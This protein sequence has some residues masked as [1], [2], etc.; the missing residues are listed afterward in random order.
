MIKIWFSTLIL[1]VICQAQ[2]LRIATDPTTP[3][4]SFLDS[5]GAN[6]GLD[7]ELLA[8]VA[9]QAGV[10]YELVP[11]AWTDLFNQVQN[12]QVDLAISDI[13]INDAREEIYDFSVPYY[14]SVH[15]ILAQAGTDITSAQDLVSLNKIVGARDATISLA[16]VER[17]LGA[18]NPNIRKFATLDEGAQALGNGEIDAYVDDGGLVDYYANN[19]PGFTVIEDNNA[20][21]KEFYG[22]MFPKGS[23]LKAVF[24]PAITAVLENGEYDRIY[25]QWFGV[26]PDVALLLR[27]GEDEDPYDVFDEE[28]EM[29]WGNEEWDD[30]DDMLDI[31]I[32]VTL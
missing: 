32:S 9:Q 28:N 29:E 2:N 22:L 31:D 11:L 1:L 7:I 23:A 5:A 24:D 16:A 19:N 4:F 12:A 14:L 30:D 15:K 3:P 21:E 10:Q 17:I 20:F 18:D 26:A 8:A 13:T 27:A 6:T 25:T